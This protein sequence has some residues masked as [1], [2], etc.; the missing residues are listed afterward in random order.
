MNYVAEENEYYTDKTINVNLTFKYI[1]EEEDIYDFSF[2]F[3]NHFLL[4]LIN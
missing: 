3:I 4:I 1:A 2:E